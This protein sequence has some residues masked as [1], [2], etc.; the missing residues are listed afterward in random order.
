MASRVRHC[1]ECPKCLTRYLP[2]LS[3]YRNGSYLMPRAEGF[4][5]EWALYCACGRPPISSRWSWNDLKLYAVPRVAVGPTSSTGRWATDKDRASFVA[6]CERG[7]TGFLSVSSARTHATNG[8]FR[9]GLFLGAHAA[10]RGAEP[11]IASGRWPMDQDG[12]SFEEG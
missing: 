5:D 2:G 6:G 7:Y 8:A 11:H 10:K 3:P 1:V 12:E 9:D 4:V